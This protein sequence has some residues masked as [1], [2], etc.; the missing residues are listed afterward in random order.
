[1]TFDRRKLSCDNRL[2]VFFQFLSCDVFG[3]G[4]LW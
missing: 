4:F 2:G 3:G 1:M